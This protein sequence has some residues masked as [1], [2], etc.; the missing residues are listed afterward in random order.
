M[1]EIPKH[2]LVPI[3][4][5]KQHPTNVKEHPQSQIDT[6]VELI[7]A[8]GFKDPVVIDRDNIIWAGHGRLI[9]AQQLGLEEIPV[10]YIDNLNEDQKKAFM[11]ADNRVN[12]SPWH[13]ENIG[14]ILDEVPPIVF[15]SFKV[16]FDE[17]RIKKHYAEEDDIPYPPKEPTVKFGETWRLGSNFLICGDALQHRL[18]SA[19]VLITDPPY[20]LGGYAGRSGNFK[21]ITGDDQDPMLFYNALPKTK[22]SYVFANWEVLQKLPYIP[23][24]VLI[25][26]KN[27]FGMGRGY[28][29]QYEIILYSG[30]FSGSDTD[31]WE[32]PK[33]AVGG[34]VHPTQKPV[35]LI[36]RALR[37]S[38]T[39]DSLVLDMFAGSGSTLIAC[40]Q[41]GVSC[42]AIEIEPA[43]C[44]V[45]IKRWEN[46]TGHKAENV[47]SG[48]NQA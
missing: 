23:Q 18:P 47:L 39:K 17:F 19:D 44:D 38:T 27:N 2:Q 48:A 35:E 41:M 14:I 26:K 33:D 30:K 29:G 45:I 20:G 4:T 46:Y 10:V 1:V 13:K 24:D 12:E 32:I 42:Y 3:D 34:Y 37:N 15:E 31:V 21:P 40:Q 6:L 22:E 7:K 36:K 11:L 28:R 25:W 8:V 5:L 16:N 9:A 43:Y